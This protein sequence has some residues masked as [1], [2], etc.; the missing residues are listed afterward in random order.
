M[1]ACFESLNNNQNDDEFHQ[2]ADD[3][4]SLLELDVV[5]DRIAIDNMIAK[6]R[7]RFEDD[8]FAMAERLKII[9][10]REDIDADDNP[11]DPKAICDSFHK[12]SETLETDIQIKLVLYKLFVKHVMTN[13]GHFY[14]EMNELFIEKGVLP[15]FKASAERI[16]KSTKFIENQTKKTSQQAA[17]LSTRENSSDDQNVTPPNMVDTPDDLL[18]SILQQVVAEN[19][20]AQTTGAETLNPVNAPHSS[21]VQNSEYMSALSNLQTDNKLQSQS[22]FEV[23]PQNFKQEIHQQLRDFRQKNNH[24]ASILDNQIIDIVSILFDFFLDDEMLPDPVKV[25]IG[26]LQI[27]ILKAA[28]IDNNFFNLQKH[29][30]RRLLDEISRASIGWGNDITQEKILIE[31]IEEYRKY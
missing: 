13:L 27:P 21:A 25:L 10:Q 1:E 24:Q 4:L 18:L 7:P 29:P 9:M 5:E 12:A 28:L 31:K 17:E 11:L 20:D 14:G 26:R 6:T 19:P 2:E 15:D 8:L 3:E 23:N 16:K 22:V 30:A